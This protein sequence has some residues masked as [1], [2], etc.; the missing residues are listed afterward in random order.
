MADVGDLLSG[1]TSFLYQDYGNLSAILRNNAVVGI[2]DVYWIA[3]LYYYGVFG[4]FLFGS[5]YVSVFL[6]MRRLERINSDFD[7]VPLIRPI[8]YLLIFSFF[9]GFVNQVFYIK[10][11]SFYFWV[12]AALAAHRVRFKTS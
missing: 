1:I 8:I 7:D 10:T 3:F 5:F 9:A 11:F 2:E 6:R 4:I 12:F